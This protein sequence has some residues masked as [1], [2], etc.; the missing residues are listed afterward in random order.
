VSQT[1][2]VRL[3][4]AL[5]VVMVLWGVATL[6][7]RP[8]ADAAARLP[9]ARVDTATV[10]TIVLVR[11]Q[12]TAT[13]VRVGGQWRVNGVTASGQS[14]TGLLRGLADT[15]S[16]SEL[17]ATAPA[18]QVKLG[19]ATD[20]ARRLRVVARGQT[21]VD[22]L[23]GNRTPDYGGVYARKVGDDAVYAWHSGEIAT[24]MTR[25]TPDW[26]DRR[27][28]AIPADS[29]AT[30]EARRG[31]RT[32]VLRRSADSVA[33]AKLLAQYKDLNASGFATPAQADTANF[34]RQPRSIRFLRADGTA[35][36]ELSFDSTSLGVWTRRASGG[37]VYRI[38]GFQ[39]PPLLP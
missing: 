8:A 37:P 15:G 1:Q 34:T 7:R 14:V 35:I 29:V 31:A 36:A 22:L 24:A 2:L 39:L 13:L 25:A 19:V 21:V 28:V 12:D 16:N 9:I 38:E 10:D 4:G 27:I 26:R 5:I 30:V 23:T 32:M 33:L 17:V 11:R 20:N 6:V 18:S 3:I